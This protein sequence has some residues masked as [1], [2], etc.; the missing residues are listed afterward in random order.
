MQALAHSHMS[1]NRLSG[2][3]MLRTAYYWRFNKDITD[4]ALANDTKQFMESGNAPD[5]LVK[6]LIHCYGVH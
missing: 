2:R 3:E 5:Y 1:V 4:L 6:Y